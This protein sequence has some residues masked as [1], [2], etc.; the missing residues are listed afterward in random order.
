MPFLKIT[1]PEAPERSVE[2][3]RH[4][5]LGRHPDNTIQVLDRIVSKNHCHIDEADGRFVLKDLGSLNGTFINGERVDK[6]RTLSMGDEI[7]LG[8]TKIV[9]DPPGAPAMT[10]EA[11]A[12][13]RATPRPPSWAA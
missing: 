6:Q 11:P 4:N 2:L 13:G 7:T 3:A 12:K 1:S 5:T 10:R 8:A 9:F